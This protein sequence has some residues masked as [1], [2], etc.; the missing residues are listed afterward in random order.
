[1]VAAH[2]RRRV[3]PAGLVPL[4]D[5]RV[6]ALPRL[7]LARR[8][9]DRH[10]G[11]RRVLALAHELLDR[12]EV[13]VRPLDQVRQRRI[14]GGVAVAGDPARDAEGDK[15][16]RKDLPPQGRHDTLGG[17]RNPPPGS[18][19]RACPGRKGCARPAGSSPSATGG[20]AEPPAARGSPTPAAP[21]AWRSTRCCGE[22]STP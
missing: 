12:L 7:E 22:T 8:V 6:E 10:A 20:C 2:G 3:P 11:E 19:G 9:L 4:G 1:V 15:K 17:G 14:A 16:K 21:P 13:L 18:G 5:A